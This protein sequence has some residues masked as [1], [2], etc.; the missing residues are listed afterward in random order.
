MLENDELV[1]SENADKSSANK[2]FFKKEMNL[3]DIFLFNL[4]FGLVP[5]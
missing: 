5:V 3:N 1:T 2:D 4:L